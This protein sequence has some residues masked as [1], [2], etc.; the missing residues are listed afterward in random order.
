M[1]YSYKP[2]KY[3]KYDENLTFEANYK[4][5]AVITKEKLDRLEQQVKENSA[6]IGI[7][8][9]KFVDTVEEASVS[10]EFNKTEGTK[11]FNF[12]IP[13]SPSSGK[14]KDGKSAYEVWL[15][16]EGNEGK[17]VEE[18]LESIKGEKGDQGE[19]GPAG[20]KGEQ[21]EVG[22]QGEQGPEGPAGKDAESPSLTLYKVYHFYNDMIQ[23]Q[24]NVPEG[25]FTAIASNDG[26]NGKIF[27][28]GPDGYKHSLISLPSV[29]FVEL[30][31]E[32]G[33][34]GPEGPA[35]EQGI[36]GEKG[37]QGPEGKSAYEQ[38]R[39]YAGRP[40]ATF[41]DF[42]EFMKGKAGDVGPQGP[43]GDKGDQGEVGPQG[44]EGK[45]GI[46]GPQGE[47][48]PQGKSA[49]DL[50]LDAGNTGTEK[51]YFASL[52][53]EKGDEGPRGKQGNRGA[54]G[55]SAYEIWRDYSGDDE[56]STLDDFY[57]FMRGEQGPQGEKGEGF[58]ISATYASVE[59]MNA[60]YDTDGL[61]IG[62]LVAIVSDIEDPDNAKLYTKGAEKYEY[63]M[64]LSGATGIQGP[65]GEKGDKGEK[66][67]S[68]YQVWLKVEGNEGKTQ[69]DFFEAIKGEK[70]DQGEQG[71]QGIQGE[72]GPK[73]D[74]GEKGDSTYQVWLDQG[75]E[76]TEAEFLASLKGDQGE[77]GPQGPTGLT[78]N[79]GKSAY[80]LWLE[81]GN[82][83]TEGDFLASL[84]GE[85]GD[86]LAKR[87][88]L[89]R[90]LIDV[91]PNNTIVN[92]FQDEVR[93]MVPSD[94]TWVANKEDNFS[95]QA[96]IFAPEGAKYCKAAL[97]TEIDESV[98]FDELTEVDENGTFYE[99]IWI[100]IALKDN[101][102]NLKYIGADSDVNEGYA[103]TYLRCDWYNENKVRVGIDCVRINCANEESQSL[104]R[105]YY[106]TRYYVKSEIDTKVTDAIQEAVDQAYTKRRTEPYTINDVVFA[107]GTAITINADADDPNKNDI[108]WYSNDGKIKHL[109]VAAGRDIYG[110]SEESNSDYRIMY[111]SASITMN[112]G[113]V[114]CIFG[115]GNGACDIGHSNVTVNGGKVVYI[116]GAGCTGLKKDNKVGFAHVIVNGCIGKP[117]VYGGSGEGYAST[118]ESLVEINGGTCGYVTAGGSNGFTGIGKVIVNGGTIDLLQG[119]NRGEMSDINYEINGGTITAMHVW[120]EGGN[121]DA[122]DDPKVQ[123]ARVK[124]LG[125]TITTL[126]AGVNTIA[127]KVVTGE[128]A[129]GVI[130]NQDEALAEMPELKKVYNQ[131]QIITLIN[132]TL[133]EAK[134]Y[135]DASSVVDPSID[136]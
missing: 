83:G 12:A 125:G 58:H 110:G 31:G 114:N 78:G 107:C 44:P 84:K 34:Q 77:V 55:K 61:E 45:Q 92:Y 127:G 19:A 67:D 66:G 94:T 118:G 124:L 87:V 7:G 20:E 11:R 26:D 122:S 71:P 50:W 22:P 24:D 42:V 89:N 40:G 121:K 56:K 95:M 126:K 47:V 106:T 48:G 15:E 132:N 59:E 62:A 63:I 4:N 90:I 21:G 28:K 130:T 68:A 111:P 99:T 100:P 129:E 39:E 18:F 133:I 96:K 6:E 8:E 103:G 53:G 91:V 52:K 113:T 69:D 109:K 116:C 115:G 54:A 64:D 16:Q 14:G 43:K 72:V 74:K 33:D 32:K 41:D 135:T 57:E 79:D 37:D 117:D 30:K 98:D 134:S 73:G 13:A 120:G 10:V 1:A 112:S 123:N 128:Y 81:A 38:W 105:P 102:G 27:L 75:N 2:N 136:F 101:D 131:E 104:E 46:Q 88:F 9:V 51:D 70:G 108:S 17:S 119:V 85:K 25:L 60:A 97:S 76:G 82:T 80:D 65:Q 29:D 86:S 35:G 93:V 23:D 3:V 36:E 5:D 49:Y